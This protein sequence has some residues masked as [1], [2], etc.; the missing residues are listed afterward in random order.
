[1]LSTDNYQ[2]DNPL[3]GIGCLLKVYFQLATIGCLLKDEQ[4]VTKE[5]GH[6]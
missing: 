3:P 5:S 6:V 1:M 4:L 2:M